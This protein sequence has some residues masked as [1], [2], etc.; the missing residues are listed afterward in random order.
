MLLS[1][2]EIT[3]YYIIFST[4]PCRRDGLVVRER[5]GID[6]SRVRI[7]LRPFQNFFLFPL[8]HLILPVFSEETLPFLRCAIIG[9]VQLNWPNLFQDLSSKF[10]LIVSLMRSFNPTPLQLES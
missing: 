2:T 10:T 4:G 3:L 1:D 9:N 8:L 6:C 7:P 5:D